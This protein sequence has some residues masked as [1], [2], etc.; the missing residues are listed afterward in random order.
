MLGEVEE[1]GM[2]ESALRWTHIVAG[3]G[4]LVAF[5]VP[6]VVRKG[7]LPHRRFGQVFKY[8]GYAVVASALTAVTLEV[9][10]A[11]ID[12]ATLSDDP[13][14]FG[15]A[16]FLAYL[17]IITFVILRHGVAVLE[18]KKDLTAMDRPLDRTLAVLSIAA[19]IALVT[20][21][22]AYRPGNAIVLLALSPI[23]I[24]AGVDILQVLKG[25]KQTEKNGWLLEHLGA[26]L[27]AGIAFHT[28]FVV[29]GMS[30]F[31]DLGLQGGW[32]VIPWILPAAIG[33][34]AIY[35]WSRKY[36][37]SVP[38]TPAKAST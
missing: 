34:P 28:A 5:W 22:I 36:R 24:T 2:L 12:G 1:M 31:V 26:L 7:S 17:A 4:G 3:F 29:F 15:F 19:S 9:G 14:G 37:R 38:R 23:G 21:T 11:L 18:H 35:L 16:F 13:E 32:A 10:G 30:R 6:V 33:T 25:R 8:C 20:Y 27:G